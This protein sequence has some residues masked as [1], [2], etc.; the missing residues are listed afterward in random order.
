[1]AG[2]AIGVADTQ[3]T[4]TPPVTQPT[5][6]GAGSSGD[7]RPPASE[8]RP[9][10]APVE[11]PATDQGGVNLSDNLIW[12]DEG[13]TERSV[14]LQELITANQELTK[15]KESGAHL[16]AKGVGG[17]A[18]AAKKYIEQVFAESEG[19]NPVP[20][21]TPAATP[22]E[23]QLPP[24]YA[25]MREYVQ[26]ARTAD[27]RGKLEAEIKNG[28]YPALAQRPGIVDEIIVSLDQVH[29]AMPEGQ[30]LTT[31]G[32]QAILKTKDTA[33][34]TYQDTIRGDRGQ[35]GDLGTPEPFRGGTPEPVSDTPPGFDD[36]EYPKW[37]NA[38]LQEGI[39][40]DQ[41]MAAAT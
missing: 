38:K 26:T 18:D 41:A 19:A 35:T 6:T 5:P 27:A 15:L 14:P 7:A 10:I 22:T 20:P 4:E 9:T 36:P 23:P 1:M 37:L 28:Q 21:V 13:G 25:E 31:Q 2:E 12:T 39:R 3:T 24:D 33:E 11:A 30:N 34:K 40:A 32:I 29:R 16:F 17:D 8:P